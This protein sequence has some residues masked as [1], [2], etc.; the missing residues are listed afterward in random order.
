GPVLLEEGV[1]LVEVLLVDEAALALIERG[2]DGPADLIAGDVAREG[3]GAQDEAR[4]RDVD[5]DV[6]TRDEQ[7]DG[8]QQRVARQDREQQ[9]ALDEDDGHADP[10]ELVAEPVE[11]PLGVHP[12]RT[13]R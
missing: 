11:K 7:A 12:V 3:R 8:E 6:A 4:D 1:R 13:E 10:E 2:A 5:A 9:T